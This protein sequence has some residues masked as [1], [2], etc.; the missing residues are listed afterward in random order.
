MTFDHSNACTARDNRI[1]GIHLQ[2]RDLQ[3]EF[4]MVQMNAPCKDL[5]VGPADQGAFA[6]EGDRGAREYMPEGDPH[7]PT[8]WLDV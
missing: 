7:L 1:G 3:F 5:A 2:C 4:R 8:I 6:R